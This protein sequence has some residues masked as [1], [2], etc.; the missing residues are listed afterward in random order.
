MRPEDFRK[1]LEISWDVW[2]SRKM[3]VF[4]GQ[5]TMVFRI[6]MKSKIQISTL[7][8]K[9]SKVFES[10]QNPS[11]VCKTYPEDSRDLGDLLR[12]LDV[13]KYNDV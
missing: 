10:L 7:F 6:S 13:L 8:Q 9:S 3:P 5:I 4:T 1:V 11:K 2:M 12:N